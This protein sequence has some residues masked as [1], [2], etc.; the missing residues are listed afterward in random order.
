MTMTS[1]NSGAITYFNHHT[2][3]NTGRDLT[4]PHNPHNTADSNILD[5]NKT[6]Y[7]HSDFNGV[8]VNKLVIPIN[9]TR[10]AAGGDLGD[11][12]GANITLSLTRGAKTYS[13]SAT[14]L[15]A[16]VQANYDIEIVI[17]DWVYTN[18]P[19]V[20][21][22]SGTYNPLYDTGLDDIA[23]G[24]VLHRGGSG[25]PFFGPGSE[26]AL[27]CQDGTTPY[28]PYHTIY[29]DTSIKTPVGKLGD[30]IGTGDV[31]AKTPSETDWNETH[32]Q[33]DTW[34]NADA[35][36][37]ATSGSQSDIYRVN[38][39]TKSSIIATIRSGQL[40]VKVSNDGTNFVTY[41]SLTTDG[42]VEL[43]G[44]SHIRMDVASGTVESA[45]LTA[46]RRFSR[47]AMEPQASRD[48]YR[49]GKFRT[50]R[51]WGKGDM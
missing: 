9:V 8:W 36:K 35:L 32:R 10:Y 28:Y 27:D 19:I 23:A 12:I 13:Y 51:G 34:F 4:P 47:C 5:F 26:W 48:N 16:G 18:D 22:F 50:M 46:Q 41:D 7:V 11:D 43:S 31:F 15:G 25:T 37:A 30:N 42:L 1:Q 3:C 39:F 17:N 33:S 29:Y 49:L 14:G 21:S 38:Q 2:I 45:A 40:D 20:F 44:F 24:W 6:M